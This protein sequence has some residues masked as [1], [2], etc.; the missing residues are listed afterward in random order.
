MTCRALE[1]RLP[2][3]LRRRVLYFEAAIEQAVAAL[4]AE[5]PAGARVLDAGAGEGQYARFFSGRRYLGLDLGIG[6]PRWNYRGLDVLGD[7]V[8]LPFG[9]GCFDAC[10]NVVT[11]EHVREPASALRE[12]ARV[13][14]PGGRLLVVVPHEWE[15]HQAPHDYFRFTRYGLSYLLETAGFTAIR[16]EPV[17]GY[18]RLLARRLLNGL[19]FFPGLAFPLAALLLAPPALVLP[20]L[21]GL[22][23]ARN[24]TLG[25]VC[26]AQKP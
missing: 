1:R 4:A 19:E 8:A 15:V 11:L 21:D 10:L 5:L 23:R 25:Y 26:T 7:L 2:R 6:D 16:I 9:S 24:F 18:F 13:L 14:K 17:G 22:D 3:F 12:I 20:W